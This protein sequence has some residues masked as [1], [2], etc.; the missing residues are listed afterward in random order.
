MHVGI[1]VAPFGQQE[2]DMRNSAK[3]LSSY[4]KSDA[5]DV[6]FRQYR[7]FI[8]HCIRS[9]Y[10]SIGRKCTADVKEDI[11]QEIALKILK[12][13]YIDRFDGSRSSMT[14]W[15]GM[16]ARTTAIDH[17]RRRRLETSDADVEAAPVEQDFD[18][19]LDPLPLPQGVL[20]DRQR[21]V[22][23]L[24]FQE[25]LD[26]LEIAGRLGISPRTVRSLKFQ[27]LERLRTHFGQPEHAGRLSRSEQ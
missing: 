1:V 24:G 5:Y 26:A 16:I 17:L 12:N 23:V 20:T 11:F 18:S 27:A 22:L 10:D 15:L 25:G 4:S 2:V 21:Q 8:L 9:F 7:N 13:G 14:T 19:G 3:E 6:I